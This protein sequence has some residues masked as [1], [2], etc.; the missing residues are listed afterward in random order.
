MALRI[1]IIKEP[2]HSRK[3]FIIMRAML[4]LTTLGSSTKEKETPSGHS[5]FE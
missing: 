4:L 1:W 5:N 2:G 3:D